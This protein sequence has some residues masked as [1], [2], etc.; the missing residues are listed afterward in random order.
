MNDFYPEKLSEEEIHRTAEELLLTYG[1]NALA[2]AEKEIRLSN[3]RGLF[4]L[5][6]SWVRVC[7]RIRQMQARDSYQDVLL[8][9]LRPDRSA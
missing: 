1:D 7:Q 9:Q 4:T 6:G 2:Q 8:E 5:S 3:S